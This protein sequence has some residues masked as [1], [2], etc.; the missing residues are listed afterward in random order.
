MPGRYRIL[1]AD[2]SSDDVLLLKRAFQQSPAAEFLQVLPNGQQV[3]DYL[4]GK[5]RFSD[6]RTYPL[7]D[8][9]IL[10]LRMPLMNGFEVLE[11]LRQRNLPVPKRVAI[12]TSEARAA[13]IRRAYELGAHFIAHKEVDFR[14]FVQRLDR[15]MIDQGR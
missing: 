4:E 5:G 8:V 10:D 11:R 1:V 7:P 6:R 12:L 3:M 13:D 15:V 14:P 2:D 9:L